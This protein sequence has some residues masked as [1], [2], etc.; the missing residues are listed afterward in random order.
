MDP[1]CTAAAAD[2]H[3]GAGRGTSLKELTDD[4]PTSLIELGGKTLVR[5][6]CEAQE[7]WLRSYPAFWRPG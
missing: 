2:P 1:H 5:W 6:Q 7:R 4:K 3:L